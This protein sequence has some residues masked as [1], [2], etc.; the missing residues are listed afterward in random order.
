MNEEQL[1]RTI[2]F[3]LQGQADFTAQQAILTEKHKEFEAA[4][5]R[6][7]IKLD[8]LSRTVRDLGLLSRNLLEV[9]QI[10]ARRL[11]RLKEIQPH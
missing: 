7:Q 5:K 2:E 9:E 1:Q 4:D 6:L 11:D 3:I 10:H 8:R